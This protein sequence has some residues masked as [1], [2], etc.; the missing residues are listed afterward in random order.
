[1]NAQMELLNPAVP[2]WEVFPARSEDRVA[3]E[4]RC[5]SSMLY[6]GPEREYAEVALHHNA[7]C[8]RIPTVMRERL[9]NGRTGEMVIEEP[10]RRRR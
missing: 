2:T 3:V 1:M 7:M 4:E 8:S 6:S 9:P 5:G 10:P